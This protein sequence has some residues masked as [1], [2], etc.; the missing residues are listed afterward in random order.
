LQNFT[1]KGSN[2]L[3]EYVQTQLL[4]HKYWRKKCS[5]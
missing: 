1:L 4:L 2:F 3:L 5:I